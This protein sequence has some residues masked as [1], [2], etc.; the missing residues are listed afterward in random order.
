VTTH[1]AATPLTTDQVPLL[2]LDVWEHAYYLDYKNDRGA[3]VD[4]FLNDLINW[5]FASANLER[6]L[7]PMRQRATG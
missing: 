3:Y 1:D 5:D 7:Q 2:T 6:Y 4:A